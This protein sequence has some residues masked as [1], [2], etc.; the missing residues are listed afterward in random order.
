ME[1]DFLGIY[2]RETSEEPD[3]LRGSAV[4]WPFS[5]KVSAMHQFMFYKSSQEEQPRN[6]VFDK[7]SSFRFQCISALDAFKANQ[8]TPHALAAQ[9]CSSVDRQAFSQYPMQAYQAQNTNSFDAMHHQLNEAK[10]F[11]LASHHSSPFFKVQHAHGGPNI[12]VTNTEQQTFRRGAAVNT[13]VGGPLV[14]AFASRNA[15]QP[16]YMTAQ[17]TIFY[18]GCVNV[19]NDVP[20]D[21]AQAIMLL[22]GKESN[23]TSNAMNPRPE[24]PATATVPIKM[25]GPNDLSLKQS[26]IPKPFCVTSTHS[27]LSSPIS[28]ASHTVGSSGNGS[29]TNDD[30]TGPKASNPL[31]PTNR[32]NVT[33][34]LSA[35]L[36]SETVETS[37]PKAVPQAR[38]ASLARFLEKRK[39]RMTSV[40]PY[41]CSKISPENGSGFE[42]CNVSSISSSADLNLS[43]N[44]ED[45]WFVAHPKGSMDSGESLSSK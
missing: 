30:T 42:S 18:A 4:K 33:K 45:S 40:M 6:H 36:G 25:A 31:V 27:G 12:T 35:A 44:R 17:L 22:A 38:K 3:L 39:E 8:K 41:S 32:K 24:V 5:N 29:S 28:I 9:K 15:P 2:G 37:T 13:P 14:G 26:S 19:Y 21:K 11:P 20:L 43:S 1:R 34:T 16:T 10:T 23:A 7:N